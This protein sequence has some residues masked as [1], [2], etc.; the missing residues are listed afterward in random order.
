MADDPPR[1]ELPKLKRLRSARQAALTKHINSFTAS[2]GNMD[3]A[4]LQHLLDSIDQV[5]TK[6]EEIEEEIILIDP[7][8]DEL[9]PEADIPISAAATRFND[10]YQNLRL[11]ILSLIE[12]KRMKEEAR[13]EQKAAT[14]VHL[15][16]LE[17][18]H[19]NG[20]LTKWTDFKN[21]FLSIT[22]DKTLNNVD[23]FRL[24]RSAL[25]EGPRQVVSS[26][27]ITSENYQQAWHA[28]TRRYDSKGMIFRAHIN[29][30][31]SHQGAIRDY[32]TVDEDGFQFLILISIGRP[33]SLKIL[34]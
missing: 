29:S 33:I 26:I 20:E 24:L 3:M 25:G 10:E 8:Y 21:E 16:S 27:E 17:L 22:K 15:P 31:L 9:E 4:S 13:R 5:H 19:F 30:I 23:R 12:S 6:F 2:Q 14:R 32:V 34:R 1:N 7:Q 18:P 28:L 11:Q